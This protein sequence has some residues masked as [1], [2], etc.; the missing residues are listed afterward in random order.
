MKLALNLARGESYLIRY[1]RQGLN[2]DGLFRGAELYKPPVY[3]ALVE[4]S[5]WQNVFILSAGWGLIRSTP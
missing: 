5:G 2:P 1:N 4:R 3:R